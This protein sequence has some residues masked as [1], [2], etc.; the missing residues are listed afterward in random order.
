MAV[1]K[2][3]TLEVQKIKAEHRPAPSR[4]HYYRD[5]K[6]RLWQGKICPNCYWPTNKKY[7]M[8]G[9]V[10][11]AVDDFN[12]DPLTDRLCRGCHKPLPTSRYFRHPECEVIET[13]DESEFT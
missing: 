3:C 8:E 11:D 7:N 13:W 6:G 1:C 10:A 4:G 9:G 12:S 2:K 5:D